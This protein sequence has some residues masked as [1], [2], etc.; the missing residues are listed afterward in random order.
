METLMRRP[1]EKTW[2]HWMG[3]RNTVP[4]LRINRKISYSAGKYAFIERLRWSRTFVVWLNA[5]YR[6]QFHWIRLGSL[7]GVASLLLGFPLKDF[8]EST[9][10]WIF[11]FCFCGH[12][13]LPGSGSKKTGLK[14]ERGPGRFYG[15]FYNVKREYLQ[16]CH[17]KRW[18]RPRELEAV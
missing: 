18:L 12:F 7:G 14:S 2:I 10:T 15:I 16:L 3:I 9:T 8:Q 11:V 6:I 1:Y 4:V 5:L 13:C 17:Y